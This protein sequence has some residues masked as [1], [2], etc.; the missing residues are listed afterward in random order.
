[1]NTLPLILRDHR[2]DLRRRWVEELNDGMDPDYREL[3]T[4]QLGERALRTFIDD[5]VTVT[6]A[7]E[8]EAP[9]I[10][11]RVE[12]QAAAAAAHWL[13]LGF[14]SQDVIR[15]LH[16]LRAAV[17]D[18]LLDALV[19]DEMPAFGESL[20]Q[21]RVVDGFLDRIVRASLVRS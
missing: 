21:L 20:A 1:M 19:L 8:Y 15:A 10:L 13:S 6:Q 18:V 3:L 17:I 11:L 9:A 16:A 12:Q 7:E 14:S 5:L 2:E 4:S